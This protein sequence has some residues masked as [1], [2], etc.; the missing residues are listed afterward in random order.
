MCGIV[1]FFSADK[2]ISAERVK[3]ATNCLRHRGPDS[4]GVWLSPN[5]RVGLGHARLS[6]IDLTS[7]DQPIPNEDGRLHIVVN[8]EFY[9]FERQRCELEQRGHQFRTRSD[10]EIA[11][12]LFEEFGAHCV[13]SLRG[14]FAFVLWDEANQSLFAAR[15]RFGIKPL[16]YAMHDSTLYFASEIKALFAAGVPKRWDYESFHQYATGPA[17][18]DRTL[19]DGVYQVPPGHYLSATRYGMR[20]LRYWEFSYPPADELGAGQPDEIAFVEEFSAVFEDAVRL[21]MRADVPVGCYLSGGLDSCA[22]LG[23]AARLSSSPIQAFTLTFDQAAYDEGDI[24]R[25]MAAQAGAKFHPVPIKQ[26]DIADNFADAIWHSET[27]CVNGGGVSKY[28]LSRAVRDAGYKVVYTGEGSD[29]IFGGYAHFRTDMLQQNAQGQ[30]ATEI[31]RQL[32]QL[33]TTNRVSRGVLIPAGRIGSLESIKRLLGFVPG[34]LKV[35]A[36]LGQQQQTLFA[37]DFE[38]RFAARDSARLF[39]DS[40]DVPAVLDRRD[41]LNKSLFVWAKSALPNYMLSVLGDRT[42]MAHSIE[43]RVPFLD[44]HVVECVSRVPVS[45]KIRGVS[46]KY[47]LREAAKRLISETVYRRQKHP[48]LAPPATTVPTG[49]FHEMMQDTLRGA[50]LASLPFYDQTKV[51][52]LLDQ[53]PAMSDSD[54]VRWDP[55]LMFVLSACVLQERFGLDSAVPGNGSFESVRIR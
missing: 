46:E 9:D 41:P 38:T 30:A 47:L 22:M 10:S 49:R 23:F 14:E 4:Q 40:L 27:V 43:G 32:Q 8:G 3:S 31:Q 19:F 39:L 54:R 7:G 18:P 2:R 52:A 42:E 50:V 53:L 25:E 11:L 48:F 55:V 33:E 29:E 17:M 28:V 35:F 16:Y 12:H 34:C 45:L 15:D 6:I 5:G 51:V 21:R 36:A 1:A 20:I 26:S 44:H 37:R 13:Q 24:A